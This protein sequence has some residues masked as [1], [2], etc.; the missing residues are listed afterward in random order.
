MLLGNVLLNVVPQEYI[1]ALELEDQVTGYMVESVE[2]FDE[3][4]SFN[5]LIAMFLERTPLI[6]IGLIPLLIATPFML[7][8]EHKNNAKNPWEEEAA[9]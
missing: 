4:M 9:A 7:K 2:R 1:T 6:V 3:T 8:I 5:G